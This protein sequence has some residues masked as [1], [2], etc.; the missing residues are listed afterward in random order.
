MGGGGSLPPYLPSLAPLSR[1]SLFEAAR[2]TARKIVLFISPSLSPKLFPSP[3]S[4]NK[5]HPY[6]D[7]DSNEKEEE[8]SKNAIGWK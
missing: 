4:R 6:Q 2:A 7:F 5:N 3:S 8:E 1:S